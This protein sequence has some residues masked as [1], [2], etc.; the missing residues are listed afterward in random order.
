M[1]S[2]LNRAVRTA[3]FA[4]HTAAATFGYT[5]LGY[6][7]RRIERDPIA[8]DMSG[9]TVVITGA[10]SGLGQAAAHEL[11]SLG[12]SVIVIGRN[13][14][15]VEATVAALGG[16][17][18]GDIADLSLLGETRQLAER[19]LDTEPRI[20]V[21]INN[22]GVLLG[23]RT[24]TDEGLET[25]A[26]TNVVSHFLLTNL[27]I[28]RLVDSAPSRIINVSSGG[29]YTQPLDVD[30]MLDH[31]GAWRGAV[32]YARAKRAQVVLT[33]MWAEQL[34]G[35]GVVVHAMHPGWAA[36]PGVSSGIPAFEK[37]TGA[38][39]RTPEQGADTIV[40]LAAADEPAET[41]GRFWL[42]REARATHQALL[43][44]EER[45]GARERLWAVLSELTGT[46]A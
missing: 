37:I 40:W 14:Q 27:L 1:A 22:A 5:K 21:L 23:E 15:K 11:S 4:G 41:S 2:F 34:D 28:P 33:E 35:R 25:S 13:Q 46:G 30:K 32:A 7:A 3:A 24:T 16:D 31:P 9:K 38:L 18:R 12:A 20:D 43:G 44:T 42:D 10:T 39:L 36:T 6:R 45:P 17:A 8:T 26:A 29:M 19:L